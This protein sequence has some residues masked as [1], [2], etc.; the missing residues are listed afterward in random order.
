[1]KIFLANLLRV[2]TKLYKSSQKGF[3]NNNFNFLK[4][5]SLLKKVKI[6]NINNLITIYKDVKFWGSNWFNFKIFMKDIYN[7][8]I[9]SI[10]CV[11]KEIRRS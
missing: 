4:K 1:M 5:T 10:F 11:P 2:K 9:T 3:Q 7:I 8:R 6:R